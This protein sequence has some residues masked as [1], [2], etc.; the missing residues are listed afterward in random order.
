MAAW[1]PPKL[2][3]VAWGKGCYIYDTDGK[4]YIDG[5][6]GPAVF[7]LGHGNEEVNAAIARQL[8]TVAHGYRYTFTR[9]PMEELTALVAERCG[10]SLRRLVFVTGGSQAG[11]SGPHAALHYHPGRGETYRGR[12]I[13]PKRK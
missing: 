1:Q 3:K 10:G 7:C 12:F 6:G 5:S 2:P 4:Q 9:D 8:D 11:D 13:P